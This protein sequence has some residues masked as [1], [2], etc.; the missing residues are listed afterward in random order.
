MIAS[1]CKKETD[2]TKFSGT[3]FVL[4]VTKTMGNLALATI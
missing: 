2:M 1:K 3:T 4:R